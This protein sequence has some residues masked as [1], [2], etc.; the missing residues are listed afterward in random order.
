MINSS[1]TSSDTTTSESMQAEAHRSS[2]SLLCPIFLRTKW[3]QI[4]SSH[5][6]DGNPHSILFVGWMMNELTRVDHY[7]ML[8]R[9]RCACAFEHEWIRDTMR[10]FIEL[11]VNSVQV[12]LADLLRV[13]SLPVIS[14]MQDRCAECLFMFEH[15]TERRTLI[16]QPHDI[17]VIKLRDYAVSNIKTLC[18]TSTSRTLQRM[19]RLNILFLLHFMTSSIDHMDLSFLTK[20]LAWKPVFTIRNVC[21][22]G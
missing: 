13:F 6:N 20:S 9:V 12:E 4:V 19:L 21:T 22:K 2:S 15:V 16:E 8:I 18:T 17:F 10:T 11:E 3:D 1:Q 14:V 7:G 5:L